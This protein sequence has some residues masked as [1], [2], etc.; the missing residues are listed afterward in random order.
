[1]NALVTGAGGFLGRHVVDA[2]LRRG[3]ASALVRPTT[4]IDD[5]PWAD[6]VNVCRADLRSP[7]PPDPAFE[8]ID[9]LVHLAARVAGSDAAQ[10]ADTVVGT[11]RLLQA[12]T[13][14]S[15]RRLVLASTF[16]V[17]D[18]TSARGALTE[19]S[20][21]AAADLYHRGGYAIAKAWQERVAR[22]MSEENGWDLTVLRPGIIWGKGREDFTRLGQKVGGWY[23]VIGPAAR[24]PLTY[25]ENCADAFAAAAEDPGRP[26]RRSTWWTATPSALGGTSANTA[27]H[28][29]PRAASADPY[30][31]ALAIALLAS[32]V[33]RGVFGPKA[34]LPWPLV[35]C[36]FRARCRPLRFGTR[37][38]RD[39]L[40][41]SPPLDLAEC[42]WRT[43]EA[44]GAGLAL[45]YQV[46]RRYTS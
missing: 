4:R 37:K 31:V 38:L 35:P 29:G 45:T 22:R 14:S 36:R 32:A 21:L 7:R 1:M 28:R 19:D 24:P 27:A 44:A 30:A 15:T 42:L 25:V 46:S 41:W 33:S 20:P 23:F 12:M 8:G 39:G 40:G 18:W 2:L 3:T 13:R 16:S 5:L 10:M 9:V 17:Y 34:N 43:C 11:E 26:A 6:R